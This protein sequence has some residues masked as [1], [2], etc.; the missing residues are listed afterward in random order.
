MT[1]SG[2][3]QNENLGFLALVNF[4]FAVSLSRGRYVFAASQALVN[5]RIAISLGTRSQALVNFIFTISLG[6]T[7]WTA[8][9]AKV[10][11]QV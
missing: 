5:L 9:P 8:S 10:A 7:F 3:L 2:T 1:C 4:I 11:S 6:T